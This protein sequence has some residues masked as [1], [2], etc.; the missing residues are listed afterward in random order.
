MTEI[1][2][3]SRQLGRMEEKLQQVSDNQDRMDTTINGM[4]ER[5]RAVE[6]RSAVTG[7]TAGSIVAGVVAAGQAYLRAKIGS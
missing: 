5:L 2:D 3:I 7:A 1:D 4:D 6:R